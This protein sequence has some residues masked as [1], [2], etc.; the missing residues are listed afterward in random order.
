[1]AISALI[2]VVAVGARMVVSRD[3]DPGPGRED[4]GIAIDNPTGVQA[5]EGVLGG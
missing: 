2:G 5:L 1:M 4:T 3:G